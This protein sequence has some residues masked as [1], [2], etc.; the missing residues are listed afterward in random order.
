MAIQIVDTARV[1]KKEPKSE[2]LEKFYT[3]CRPVE[4]SGFLKTYPFLIPLLDEAYSKIGDYFGSKPN[5][6]LEVVTDP[7]A[8]DDR[9]LV[10]YI[11]TQFDVDEA[12]AR[13]DQ[14]DE[15]WWFKA[16]RKGH[17]K[18]CIHLE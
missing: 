6:V 16:S 5:I 4:V 11:Q 7:E 10:A 1:F 15:N 12:L 18:L 8:D 3:F 9:Q 2:A 17:G 13:L 14:L